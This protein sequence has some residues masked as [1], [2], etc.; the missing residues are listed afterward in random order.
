M[1]CSFKGERCLPND[2]NV[3]AVYKLNRSAEWLVKWRYSF[4]YT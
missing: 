3:L 4:E 1:F 2:A